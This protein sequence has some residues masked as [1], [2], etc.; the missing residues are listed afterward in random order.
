[1]RAMDAIQE[2]VAYQY[3]TEEWT[4]DY[5]TVLGASKRG[6]STWL[7]G[8]VDSR[9]SAI[10]PVVLDA[11]HFQSF[12]HHQFQAYGGW[13]YAL[14]DFLEMD[15]MSRVD[16]PEMDM[17]A[18][19]DDPFTYMDRLTMPKL[20]VNAVLDEFQLPD[21]SFNWFNELPE[22]K[23]LLMTPNADHTEATGLLEIISA[24]S[25]FINY[26]LHKDV[27]QMPSMR[28]DISASDGSIVATLGVGGEVHEA[29]VWYAYS[30]GTNP[31]GIKRRDFR[32]ASL[33]YPCECGVFAQG[34]CVNGKVCVNVTLCT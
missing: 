2:F 33:D 19:M 18:T 4:L 14:E 3:P 8:A 11:I 15:I 26:L 24:M 16:T 25:F 7:V 12:A 27:E 13:T 28:W 10:I 23:H 32:L 22:P 29:S 34:Y 1:M 5:F 30:C 31:D 9:V 20:V 21:D 6:W 17:W